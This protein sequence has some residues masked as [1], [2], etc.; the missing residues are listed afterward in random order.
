MQRAKQGKA[1]IDRHHR[2]AESGEEFQHRGGQEGDAQNCE[3]AGL[4]PLGPGG[5]IAG[6]A[7]AGVKQADV[8]E[9]AKAIHQ[10]GVHVA[11]FG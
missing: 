3:G 4:Q 8:E 1:D 7:F 10:K 9:R 11:D 5:E 6:G 2:Y